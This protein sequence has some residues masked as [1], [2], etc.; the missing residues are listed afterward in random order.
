MQYVFCVD[1]YI[2]IVIWYLKKKKKSRIDKTFM[3]NNN[4]ISFTRKP[5]TGT[6]DDD[7]D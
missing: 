5:V 7:R 3:Y 1:T 2:G 4:N 6:D